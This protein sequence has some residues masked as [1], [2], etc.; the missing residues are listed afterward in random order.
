MKLTVKD[1]DFI[2]KL[3]GL[4]E[5]KELLIHHKEDGIKRLVLKQNYGDKISKNYSDR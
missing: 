5:E 3:K 2:A 4:I 1:K